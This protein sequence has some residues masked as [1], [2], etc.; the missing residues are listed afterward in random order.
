MRLPSAQP[1][2]W[3]RSCPR[4]T[5]GAEQ[6]EIVEVLPALRIVPPPSGGPRAGR[7]RA[8]AYSAAIGSPSTSAARRRSISASQRAQVNVSST[9]G[10]PTISSPSVSD[11]VMPVTLAVHATIAIRSRAAD[12]ARP[13]RS[14]APVRPASAQ[15][16]SQRRARPCR[17]SGPDGRAGQR[18]AS[19]PP[20]RGSNPLGTATRTKTLCRRF[21]QAPADGAGDPR[22]AR[23]DVGPRETRRRP[24]ANVRIRSRSRSSSKRD[25]DR[26]KP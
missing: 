13:P 20:V 7:R 9:T 25:G 8:A 4:R 12:T 26:W 11:S 15:G 24:P 5:D 14:G 6:G 17:K 18:G 3:A 23:G 21:R 2:S 19:R 22:G 10:K 16:R 1:H